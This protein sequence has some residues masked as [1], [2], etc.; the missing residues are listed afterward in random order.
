MVWNK[1]QRMYVLLWAGLELVFSTVG[2]IG[3]CF[4]SALKM[5]FV[6]AEKRLLAQHQGLFCFSCLHFNLPIAT[7][8]FNLQYHLI[9]MDT[10]I[11][12]NY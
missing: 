7:E 10:K 5:V 1:Q 6:T 3:L 8:K 4:G 11:H 12:F 9:F 2:G